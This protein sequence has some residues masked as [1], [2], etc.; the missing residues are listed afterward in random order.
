[1]PGCT[2]TWQRVRRLTQGW[3]CLWSPGGGNATTLNGHCRC[4]KALQQLGYRP[5]PVSCQLPVT[6]EEMEKEGSAMALWV[7]GEAAG[8]PAAVTSYV[9]DWQWMQQHLKP[10]CGSSQSVSFCRLLSVCLLP[11]PFLHAGTTCAP[12]YRDISVD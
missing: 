8:V 9:L 5:P 12:S 10:C 4:V 3:Q 7:A 11:L 1:M 6:A 2:S